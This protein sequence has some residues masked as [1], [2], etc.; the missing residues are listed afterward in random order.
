ME[1]AVFTRKELYALVWSTPLSRIARKYEISDTG[2]RKL[3]KRHD[4]PV[5]RIGHWQKVTHGKKVLVD[6][7]KETANDQIK[8]NLKLRDPSH[9]KVVVPGITPESYPG[10]DF[11]VPKE[12]TEPDPMIASTQKIMQD[13]IKEIQK[14]NPGHQ[15]LMHCWKGITMDVSPS[16]L[17]RALCFMDTLI[18][19]LKKRDHKVECGNGTY[20]IIGAQRIEISLRERTTRVLIEKKQN[21]N[22]YEYVPNGRLCL[23]TDIWRHPGWSDKKVIL[24]FQLPQILQE[25]EAA[26]EKKRLDQ[27]AYEERRREEARLA[28]LRRQ[29]EAREEKEL[30]ALQS[31]MN[32]A[33]RWQQMTML[34]KYISDMEA[35]AKSKDNS[36]DDMTRWL[37]W[38][39]Q[40][41]DWLDP[42]INRHDELLTRVDKYTLNMK[43]NQSYNFSYYQD[44]SREKEYNFWQSSWW[45]RR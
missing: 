43:R 21:W 41:A 7:F 39:K 11:N 27:I 44:H 6:K 2:L 40:K 42:S 36:D 33:L 10:I 5:P 32:D 34:R 45:N 15:R 31:L 37:V 3:C 8:I 16:V 29:R 22:T 4:I 30:Q 19:I 25:L 17:N 20:V 13:E 12:L 14:H 38:A 28:E 9:S 35:L 23:K 24:E 1:Q 18:K 26:A